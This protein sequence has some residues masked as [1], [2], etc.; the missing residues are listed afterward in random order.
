M[1]N[2]SQAATYLFPKAEAVALFGASR[3]LP[4]DTFSSQSGHTFLVVLSRRSYL[5]W[6][7]RNL[8][9]L[10]PQPG[11]AYLLSWADACT[12]HGWITAL[13]GADLD[14]AIHGLQGL[15]ATMRAHQAQNGALITDPA[16]PLFVLNWQFVTALGEPDPLSF[17]AANARYEQYH[18]RCNGDSD[19]AF[20]L[21]A[22]SM[23]TRNCCSKQ[24]RKTRRLSW[25]CAV[26]WPL[27]RMLKAAAPPALPP[28]A[29]PVHRAR[30]PTSRCDWH[31]APGSG[32][33]PSG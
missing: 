13:Y 32:P 8:I 4:W 2:Y 21:V 25:P 27:V 3:I 24:S 28:P 17:G 29:C 15:T 20:S 12:E 14:D 5:E 11:L 33:S 7:L 31:S 1:P 6:A 16:D 10:F 22:L 9:T 23:H 26:S 19:D 30:S 18:E